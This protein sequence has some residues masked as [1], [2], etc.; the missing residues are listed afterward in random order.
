[1]KRIALLFFVSV[2]GMSFLACQ[3]EEKDVLVEGTVSE[4]QSGDPIQNAT[5]QVSSPEE[6]TDIFSRTDSLGQYELTGIDVSEVTDLQITASSS[7]Y[8]ERTRSLKVAPEDVVTDFDFELTE[9]NTGTP[10]GDGDDDDDDSVTGES[11]GAARLELINVSEESINVR[12]TGG[13]ENSTFTFAVLDS[14]GRP[15]NL[16]NSVEVQFNMIKSPGGGE[17]ILP[18]TV[19]T[20]AQGRVVG[21]LASGD[22]SGV[23]RLEALIERPEV[24]LIIRSTPILIAIQSGFPAPD[25]FFIAPENYNVEGFGIVPG[26]GSTTYDYAVTASVGDKHGNPVKEG[27]AVDFRTESA[28][29]IE[30]S[31]LTDENGR[32]TVLLRPD[33]ST[34]TSSPRGIG[35]FKVFAKTVDEN[36]DYVRQELEMLFTTRNASISVSPQTVEIPA[37]GSQRFSFTVT[38]LNGNPMAAGTEISVDIPE[39]LEASG[40]VGFTL[41]DHLTPGPGSTEFGFTVSD[42]DDEDSEVVGTTITIRVVSASSG[43]ETTRTIQGTRAKQ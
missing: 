26:E 41:S 20:N 32:A 1:M 42:T 21:N 10:G 28:G 30:G 27:T 11:Q 38:D 8:V 2:L 36:N 6:F 29:I 43:S 3:Q 33:G 14:A 40:D 31:A 34:P 19:E 37:N 25:R 7:D 15:I 16:D 18:A 24:G 5:V 9:E 35:F 4:L 17:T 13:V 22:S 39:G 12:G 23:V